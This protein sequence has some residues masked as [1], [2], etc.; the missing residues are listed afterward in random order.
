ME[1]SVQIKKEIRSEKMLAVLIQGKLSGEV[2]MLT[3]VRLTAIFSDGEINRRMPIPTA[4]L[5]E[6]KEC[7]FSGNSEISLKDVFLYGT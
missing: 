4:L 1:I 3:K 5:K 6:E 2:E 7:Y